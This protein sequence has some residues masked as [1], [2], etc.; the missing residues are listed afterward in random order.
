MR[1]IRGLTILVVTVLGTSLPAL[2]QESAAT[3]RAI[4]DILTVGA[5]PVTDIDAALG[6]EALAALKQAYDSRQDEPIWSGVGGVAPT[7]KALLDRLS[8]LPLAPKLRPL[9][10]SASARLG[11]TDAQVA[12]E[13]DLLL[14]ALYG[15]TAQ[16]LNAKAPDDLEAALTEFTRAGDQI[17]L[18][19]EPPAP[20]PPSPTPPPTQSGPPE[21]PAIAGLRRVLD[22]YRKQT[23][24]WPTVPEGQKLQLG[25]NGARVDAL[26]S[27]LLA[28]GDLASVVAPGT[29]FDLQLKSALQQFQTRHGLSAD[30]VAGAQTIETLNVPVQQRIATLEANLARRSAAPRSWGDRYLLVNIAAA[31]YRLIDGGRVVQAGPVLV[32]RIAAP[33]PRL[34][35]TIRRLQLHPFWLIPQRATAELWPKQ[36]ADATYFYSH[37][38]HVVDDALRQDP[39]PNNPLGAV[40]LPIDEVPGLALHDTPD[41]NAF[42]APD[43]FTSFGCVVISGAEELAKHLLTA[44][45][46]WPALR[47]DSALRGG[48]QTITLAKPLPVHLVYDTAWIEPDGTVTFRPD[49]YGWDKPTSNAAT[50]PAVAADACAG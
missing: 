9:A 37:G 10:D 27:R 21:D 12:A 11:A 47:A 40:R 33:T 34:D 42:E 30:G 5:P 2:A 3:A 8:A 4:G 38:I 28:T 23:G 46:Q 39:G 1:V 6:G 15:A 41:R 50:Q 31:E 7:A 20:A 32:G 25:D 49:P 14:S 17:A 26:R 19:R 35:G 13:R 22:A 24:D 44:D 45:P 18:L 16:V 29:Q 48:T 36:D 43:R